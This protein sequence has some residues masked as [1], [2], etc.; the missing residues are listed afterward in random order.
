MAAMSR[1][2]FNIHCRTLWDLNSK[3][4]KKN[5]LTLFVLALSAQ[6]FSGNIHVYVKKRMTTECTKNRDE[7]H[8]DD[9]ICNR[10]I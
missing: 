8:T 3:T 9:R 7:K 10:V 6:L 1:H 4:Q 5:Q 2:S